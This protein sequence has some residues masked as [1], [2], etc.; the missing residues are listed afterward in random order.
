MEEFFFIETLKSITY[1]QFRLN[2]NLQNTAKKYA[3]LKTLLVT[4]CIPWRGAIG[5]ESNLVIVNLYFVNH[6]FTQQIFIDSK[7]RRTG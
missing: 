6:L 5:H 7:K 1:I 3:C 4:I 2:W